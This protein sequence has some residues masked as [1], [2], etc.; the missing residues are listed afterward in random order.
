M[1]LQLLHN[2]FLY[3]LN[4]NRITDISTYKKFNFI[5]FNK[6]S[7]NLQVVDFPFVPVTTIV[8]I[9]FC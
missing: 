5:F 2:Y 1:M 9:I 7:N 3:S 8:L 4:Q 6:C